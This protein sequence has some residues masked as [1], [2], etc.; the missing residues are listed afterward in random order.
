MSVCQRRLQADGVIGPVLVGIPRIKSTL[1]K[2]LKKT[3]PKPRDIKGLVDTGASMSAV[4]EDILRDQL[5]LNPVDYCSIFGIGGSIRI[6]FYDVSLVMEIQ[7]QQFTFH[8]I[9]VGGLNLS[10]CDFDCVIGR[11]VLKKVLLIY[12]G[13]FGQFT[14]CS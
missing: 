5:Q 2:R 10:P 8:L 9:R 3:T 14:L 12:N 1:Y 6:P 7:Q 13:L 4:S 11:D